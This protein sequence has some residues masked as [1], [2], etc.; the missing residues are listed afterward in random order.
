[1]PLQLL[2]AL[3]PTLP[4][5]AEL[6]T[7]PKTGVK[8]S[9]GVGVISPIVYSIIN[10]IADCGI[11]CVTADEWTQLAGAVITLVIYLNSKAKKTEREK[12]V[13]VSG[14]SRRKPTRSLFSK[15]P[16]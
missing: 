1:M 15:R 8:E 7:K 4:K 10:T 6:F 14:V 16:R 11:S 5:L 12:E 3:I 2:L 9:I 13:I